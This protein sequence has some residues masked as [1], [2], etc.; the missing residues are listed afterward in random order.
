M[1]PVV[2]AWPHFMLAI[3]NRLHKLAGS[4]PFDCS[5]MTVNANPLHLASTALN[6]GRGAEGAEGVLFNKMALC[7][8]GV[9]AVVSATQ[10]LLPAVREVLHLLNQKHDKESGRCRGR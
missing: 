3:S 7:C 4:F 5:Q 9:M 1:A 10:V 2:F 8:M 6:M